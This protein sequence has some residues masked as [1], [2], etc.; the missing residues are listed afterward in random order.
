MLMKCQSLHKR[1]S[2]VKYHLHKNLSLDILSIATIYVHDLI[3]NEK[4]S[5]VFFLPSIFHGIGQLF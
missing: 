1:A 2:I 5:D 3:R 4:K